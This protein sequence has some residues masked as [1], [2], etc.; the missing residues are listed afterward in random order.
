MRGVFAAAFVAVLLAAGAAVAGEPAGRSIPDGKTSKGG[1]I[2]LI[3]NTHTLLVEGIFLDWGCK[4]VAN[5]KPAYE[6]V[7]HKGI[8]KLSASHKLSLKV[9]LPYTKIGSSKVLGRGWVTLAAALAWRP[10]PGVT[11]QHST[12][13]GTV[14]VA[15][16][17]C[18]SGPMTFTLREH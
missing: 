7:T 6:I 3:Y 1:D 8:G 14:S 10:S 9:F 18:S 11:N 16:G 12:G 2:G 17:P 15:T 4:S 5:G 13:K